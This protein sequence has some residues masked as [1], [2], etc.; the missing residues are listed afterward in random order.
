MFC[1]RDS[2]SLWFT[3]QSHLLKMPKM[4]H[5]SHQLLRDFWLFSSPFTNGT[6]I[7]MFENYSKKSHFLQLCERSELLNFP[8]N[9]WIFLKWDIFGFSNTV[10]VCTFCAKVEKSFASEKKVLNFCKV[11]FLLIFLQVRELV[12]RAMAT[13]LAISLVGMSQI[14]VLVLLLLLCQWAKKKALTL[15]DHLKRRKRCLQDLPI[16]FTF[17]YLTLGNILSLF[18]RHGG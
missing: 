5:A 9:I 1:S 17:R 15:V 11:F 12:F 13:C 3:L 4:H 16:S 18:V 14:Q 10:H 8:K 2:F 7:T 6:V